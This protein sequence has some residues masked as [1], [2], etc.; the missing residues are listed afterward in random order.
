MQRALPAGAAPTRPATEGRHLLYE[1]L[2]R[3]STSSVI[4][5]IYI[6]RFFRL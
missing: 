5:A 2:T 1:G 6:Y 4:L 3:A